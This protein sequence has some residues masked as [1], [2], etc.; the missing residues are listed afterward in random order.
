MLLK[1]FFVK[2]FSSNLGFGIDKDVVKSFL[3]RRKK[4]EKKI[5][6]NKMINLV[7]NLDIK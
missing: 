6:I 3:K 1:F 7:K 4:N 2:N 5:K